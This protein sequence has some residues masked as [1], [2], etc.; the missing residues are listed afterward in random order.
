MKPC[1]GE[2]L[3]KPVIAPM[4]RRGQQ[5]LC[6]AESCRARS[7]KG[8]MSVT[9]ETTVNVPKI[10]EQADERNTIARTATKEQ[11]CCGMECQY[12]ENGSTE[13]AVGIQQELRNGVLPCSGSLSC[14]NESD[15]CCRLQYRRL[16][17]EQ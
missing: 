11:S 3:P 7:A 2:T 8:A 5:D 12:S 9:S 17:A 15:H 6:E 4:K 13:N 14:V 1:H 10:V 16:T